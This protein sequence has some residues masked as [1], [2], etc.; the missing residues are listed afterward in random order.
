[1]FRLRRSIFAVV[2][3]V[4]SA[5]TPTSL[6]VPS[7]QNFTAPA[8]GTPT[9]SAPASASAGR[10]GTF[11]ILFDN[12]QSAG[13]DDVLLARKGKSGEWLSIRGTGYEWQLRTRVV[14][15]IREQT[16]GRAFRNVALATLPLVTR[17]SG[18][19]GRQPQLGTCPFSAHGE[20]VAQS[21]CTIDVC[22]MNP[23]GECLWGEPCGITSANDVGYGIALTNPSGSLACEYD[24]AADTVDCYDESA[25]QTY[26]QPRDLFLEI[27]QTAI[28]TT[29]RCAN[30]VNYGWAEVTYTDPQQ[31]QIIPHRIP[32]IAP[33]EHSW[34]FPVDFS[35]YIKGAVY[36]P[37]RPTTMAGLYFKYGRTSRLGINAQGF[38][39]RTLN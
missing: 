14:R 38:C 23:W 1:V 2:L 26:D 10:K 15:A 11:D 16:E 13:L 25:D 28:D 32:P 31:N 34:N 21:C 30:P 20:R 33:G 8:S 37:T 4:G 22:G 27:R 3:V 18:Y 5:C 39:A 29:M 9:V 12:G 6:V 7:Q 36:P 24:F 19:G 17:S 35:Q